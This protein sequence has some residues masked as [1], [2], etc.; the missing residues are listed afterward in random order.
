MKWGEARALCMQLHAIDE[1]GDGGG[2]GGKGGRAA[3]GKGQHEEEEAGE[4]NG[5]CLQRAW[6]RVA[7]MRRDIGGASE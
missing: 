5:P 4:R 6:Q 3:R 1:G 2:R 7:E